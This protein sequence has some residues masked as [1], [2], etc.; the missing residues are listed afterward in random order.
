[1]SAFGT[2][3][4]V[5][6]QVTLHRA[7]RVSALP[8]RTAVPSTRLATSTQLFGSS[9][10]PVI[11][12]LHPYGNA[13]LGSMAM[14]DLIAEVDEAL[15]GSRPG[16]KSSGQIRARTAA[17]ECVAIESRSVTTVRRCPTLC[18]WQ[19]CALYP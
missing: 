8:A 4:R 1:M 5:G 13:T 17:W 14:P 6:I 12:S 3:L 9:D 10:L 15:R 7:G 11:G 16:P 18:A 19:S 2:M